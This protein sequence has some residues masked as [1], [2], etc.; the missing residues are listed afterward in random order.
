MLKTDV[1][2]E[3][4]V[5]ES[6][7]EAREFLGGQITSLVNNAGIALSGMSEEPGQRVASFKKFISVNLVGRLPSHTALH[8]A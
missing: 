7:E 3:E 8:L 4:S 2:E 6:V 1:S 5:R